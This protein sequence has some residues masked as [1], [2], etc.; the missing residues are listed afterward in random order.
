MYYK[1]GL[2]TPVPLKDN[3]MH[4]YDMDFWSYPTFSSIAEDDL[5]VELFTQEQE[6]PPAYNGENVDIK[7]HLGDFAFSCYDSMEF[8]VQ[9]IKNYVHNVGGEIQSIETEK[10]R[11]GSGKTANITIPKDAPYC[12]NLKKIFDEFLHQDERIIARYK[13]RHEEHKLLPDYRK[14]CR[15]NWGCRLDAYDEN[16]ASFIVAVVTAFIMLM[17]YL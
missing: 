17:I 9:A 6:N 8:A 7:I 1:N 11:D 3:I 14:E 12:K 15:Y 5:I 10:F 16:L 13:L 4:D 2:Y